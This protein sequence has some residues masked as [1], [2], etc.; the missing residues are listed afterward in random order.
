MEMCDAS[1]PSYKKY[2]GT[3]PFDHGNCCTG[4]NNNDDNKLGGGGGDN[5]ETDDDDMS[6]IVVCVWTACVWYTWYVIISGSCGCGC[7]SERRGEARPS[8]SP[9]AAPLL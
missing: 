1:A 9:V 7:D 8:T 3:L 2:S 4:A 5:A 6:W